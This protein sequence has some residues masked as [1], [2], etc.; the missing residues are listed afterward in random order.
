MELFAWISN[1]SDKPSVVQSSRPVVGGRETSG[2]EAIGVWN[3]NREGKFRERNYSNIKTFGQGKGANK[4]G[5]RR[6]IR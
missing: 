3:V 1:E 4:K 5:K 2:S 6:R